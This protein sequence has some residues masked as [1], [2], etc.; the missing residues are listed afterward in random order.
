MRSSCMLAAIAAVAFVSFTPRAEAITLSTDADAISAASRHHRHVGHHWRARTT[1]G[2]S[3]SRI[4][5]PNNAGPTGSQ[6][7]DAQQG[8]GGKFGGR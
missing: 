5:Q 1:T 4:S 6:A 3:G 7:Y 2:F 8:L